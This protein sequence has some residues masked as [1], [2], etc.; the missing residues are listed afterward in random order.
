MPRNYN[1]ASV[2][3]W[4]AGV[5][6]SWRGKV[7]ASEDL[8]SEHV[9]K[10]GEILALGAGFGFLAPERFGAQLVS[11]ATLTGSGPYTSDANCELV[12]IWSKNN[13]TGGEVIPWPVLIQLRE[14]NAGEEL[15]YLYTSQLHS[16]LWTQM[17]LWSGL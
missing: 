15:K 5:L 13:S 6:L 16:E 14:I 4:K 9:Y 3:T 1:P 10:G 7:Y 12:H 8:A 17:R 11:C 2:D